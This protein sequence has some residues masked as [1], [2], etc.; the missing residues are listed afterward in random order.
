MIFAISAPET[1]VHVV[2]AYLPAAARRSVTVTDKLLSTDPG[3]R[4]T[5]AKVETN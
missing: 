3:S 1:V 2:A 5:L 4:W